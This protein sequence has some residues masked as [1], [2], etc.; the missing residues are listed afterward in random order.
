MK[1]AIL[2]SRVDREDYWVTGGLVFKVKNTETYEGAY[3]EI[4]HLLET[5]DL[6]EQVIKDNCLYEDLFKCDDTFIFRGTSWLK[7][8]RLCFT[9]MN[10]EG[11]DV[12][13]KMTADFVTICN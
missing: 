5:R 3:N 4:K 2:F 13:F 10:D 1:N 8:Y 7:N 12:E 9:F 6:V 11:E